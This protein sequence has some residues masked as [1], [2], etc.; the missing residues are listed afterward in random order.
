ME[1]FSIFVKLHEDCSFLVRK[2]TKAAN[3]TLIP[4]ELP[5]FFP[6]PGIQRGHQFCQ[7]VAKIFNLQFLYNSIENHHA[8]KQKHISLLRMRIIL[9]SQKRK[10][11]RESRTNLKESM[12]ILFI[13]AQV[14]MDVHWFFYPRIF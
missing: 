6:L 10:L 12:K 3:P 7:K 2:E 8:F 1:I 5:F 9:I 14:I 13:H 11:Y 4:T